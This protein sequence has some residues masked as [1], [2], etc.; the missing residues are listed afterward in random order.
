MAASISMRSEG[1]VDACIDP[2][3]GDAVSKQPQMKMMLTVKAY[4]E[5]M[6]LYQIG[7]KWS[8]CQQKSSEIEEC[9]W[10]QGRILLRWCSIFPKPP[11]HHHE[12]ASKRYS[13]GM[14]GA[15]NHHHDDPTSYKFASAGTLSW[16]I[17]HHAYG[18]GTLKFQLGLSINGGAY[19][20]S[21]HTYGYSITAGMI[22]ALKHHRAYGIIHNLGW[23]VGTM[24]RIWRHRA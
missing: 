6:M 17:R 12:K 19:F 15:E 18:D 7:R 11:S 14:P 21:V 9:C 20:F 13:I 16:K 10:H 4:L 3:A 1:A 23:T 22:S 24:T 5:V 2:R 8:W